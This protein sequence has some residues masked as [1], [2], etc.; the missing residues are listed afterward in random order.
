MNALLLKY[1]S[2]FGN[3][4]DVSADDAIRLLDAMIAESDETLLAKLFVAW[5]AKGIAEEEIYTFAKIMR[6]RCKR[7]RS[8]HA[9]FVDIVGTGGSRAKTFN[10]STAAAF[11]AAGAGFA[12]AK[13]GNKAATSMSGSADVLSALGV[14]PDV[15]AKIAEKHLNEIG[16]CFMFAP[17][18]HRL[19]PVLGKVR[20]GLGFPTVF[21]CVGPLC[22]P[23]GAPH[24]LIGVWDEELLPKMAGALARL[25]TRKSWIVHGEGGIDEISLN[26]RTKVAEVLGGSV[27]RFEIEA[28]DFN[29][30]P[31]PRDGAASLAPAESAAMI[32]GIL[33]NRMNGS[34]AEGTVLINAIAAIYL[35]GNARHVG[36]ALGPASDSIRN[37]HGLR[38]L[39]R[40]AE[41]ATV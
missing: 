37:G 11:V 34:W 12:V 6:A 10:V 19:S 24:Q 20:R 28:A 5:N 8:K 35:A 32:R 36:D 7:V 41:A 25:G 9:S 17:N 29:L 4:C 14:K 40:L 30:S 2:E 26:G 3:G 31:I 22:N 1:V 38:K 27:M 13:H 15:D 21:N 23:A 18:F 33:G 39:D 16:I